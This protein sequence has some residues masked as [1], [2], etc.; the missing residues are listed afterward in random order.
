MSSFSLTQGSPFAFPGSAFQPPTP[1]VVH[2]WTVRPGSAKCSPAAK[3][4][5]SV[6]GRLLHGLPALPAPSPLR[7]EVQLDASSECTVCVAL[8]LNRCNEAGSGP[9]PGQ[10]VA[11]SKSLKEG[12]PDEQPL[13]VASSPAADGEREANGTTAAIETETKAKDVH[14]EMEAKAVAERE[15]HAIKAAENGENLSA[16]EAK[17]EVRDGA[18]QQDEVRVNQA[19]E[20]INQADG[21]KG[22]DVLGEME[23]SA[24]VAEREGEVTKVAEN[25]VKKS[26]AESKQEARDGAVQQDEG[27]RKAEINKA[28]VGKINESGRA[29]I[30]QAAEAGADQDNE[31]KVEPSGERIMQ[32]KGVKVNQAEGARVNE[33]EGLRVRQAEGEDASGGL[34]SDIRI[35][36]RVRTVFGDVGT[37]RYRGTTHFKEGEWVGLELDRP[38]GK[39]D[40]EVRGVRYFRQALLS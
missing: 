7:V 33:A 3:S 16:V 1:A 8:S 17:Q 21:A 6:E 40:G 14:G 23:A 25:G 34:R 31:T 22:T 13:P 27:M 9:S 4:G 2:P 5:E 30:H 10:E 39:N 18:V 12:Q 26:A 20:A 32:T 37:V 38:K 36:C 28:D 11:S 15:G 29:S 24:A 35:G 19:E